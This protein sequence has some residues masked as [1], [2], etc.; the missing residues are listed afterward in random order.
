MDPSY[1]HLNNES[2]VSIMDHSLFILIMDSGHTLHSFQSW[3]YHF[4]SQ[5]RTHPL[6]ISIIDLPFVNLNHGPN[7]LSI[8]TIHTLF[9]QIINKPPLI[10]FSLSALFIHIYDRT[11]LCI[12]TYL[13]H[14]HTFTVFISVMNP[15][16]IPLYHKHTLY[17]TQSLI[18]RPLFSSTI[19]LL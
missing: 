16:F 8:F 6:I 7:L 13:N 9:I 5:S 14:G 11:T 1:F 12:F 3:A 18:Q 17:S 4:S 15:P 2:T 19:L 10:K